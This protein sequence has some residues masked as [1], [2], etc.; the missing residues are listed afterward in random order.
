[1]KTITF[2]DVEINALWHLLWVSNR[3]CSSGCVIESMETSK[4]NCDECE[5]TRAVYS[6]KNKIE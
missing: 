2:T 1:M 3:A 6:I 5:F 4:K